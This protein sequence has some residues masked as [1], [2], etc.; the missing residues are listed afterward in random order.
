MNFSAF[1]IRRN[2]RVRL[3]L[4]GSLP[5]LLITAL[6]TG[7]SIHSR[8]GDILRRVEES[9]ARMIDYLSSTLDFALYSSNLSLLKNMADTVAAIPGIRGAIFLDDLGMSLLQDLVNIRGRGLS[10]IIP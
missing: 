3:L 1:D 10:A 7:Y 5:L 9:G 8:H 4:I 6:L 2:L